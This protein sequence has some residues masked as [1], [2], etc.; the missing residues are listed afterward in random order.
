MSLRRALL[1]FA[2]PTLV[3]LSACSLRPR[4]R[5]MV[6]PVGATQEV[7]DGQILLMRVVEPA[8]GQPIPGVR[9]LAGTG[10]A[11][12]A[13][14]SDSEGR[15][16]VTVSQALLAENPLVEV[17]LPKGVRQYQFQVV[18]PEE[19]PAPAEPS[20]PAEPPAT[21]APATETPAP[22]TPAGTD[23]PGSS[24]ARAAPRTLSLGA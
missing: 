24:S 17:V 9:V 21:E 4:Y 10:R 3:L 8:T 23:A 19:T 15:L 22:E 7:V 14:T 11:R 13:S 20:M 2:L 18:R 6:Q 5:D 1:S 16:S 12:L